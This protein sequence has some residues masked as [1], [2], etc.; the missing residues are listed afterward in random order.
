MNFSYDVFEQS[1][2]ELSIAELQQYNANAW[3][4]HVQALGHT[5]ANRNHGVAVDY[6]REL[7]R[8]GV[9]LDTS[10]EGVFNGE[11]SW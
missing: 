2:R 9:V 3:I 10:I 1:I 4:T 5:K 7:T 6:A 11:G 8:R